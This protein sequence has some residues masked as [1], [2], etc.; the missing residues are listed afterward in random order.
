MKSSQYFQF[1]QLFSN[2]ELR[3]RCFDTRKAQ[4]LVPFTRTPEQSP[5][6]HEIRWI[7]KSELLHSRGSE[8]IRLAEDSM[9]SA[10]KE[11]SSHLSFINL[12]GV[13]IPNWQISIIMYMKHQKLK[14]KLQPEK[15]TTCQL[16]HRQT[17]WATHSKSGGIVA[18]T[19][20]SLCLNNPQKTPMKAEINSLSLLGRCLLA[21]KLALFKL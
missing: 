12:V 11:T 8:L 18:H 14:K 16:N 7:A 13:K 2:K 3:Q 20:P 1:D 17:S 4:G 19:R 9:K 10:L 15:T 21:A 5:F 6:V